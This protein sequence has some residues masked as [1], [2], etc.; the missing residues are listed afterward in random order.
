MQNIRKQIEVVRAAMAPSST[1]NKSSER[2]ALDQDLVKRR[3]SLLKQDVDTS[4]ATEEGL[5]REFERE[6]EKAKIALD[7]ETKDETY[8]QGIAQIQRLYDNILKR[9]EDINVVQDYGGYDTQVITPPERGKVMIS[10]VLLIFASAL[11]IGSLIGFAGACLVDISDKS[12]RT[13]EEIRQGMTCPVLGY[14]PRFR[15]DAETSRKAQLNGAAPDASLCTYYQPAMPEAEAYRSVRTALFFNAHAQGYKVIQITSPK[16]GDGKTTLAANLAFS[17]AQSGKKILLVDADL[18]N[19]CVSKVFPLNS[20]VGLS[21]VLAD[22]LDLASAIQPSLLPGLSILPCGPLPSNPAELLTSPR[23]QELLESL[24][25]QYDFVLV[26]TPPLL[27]VTDPSVVAAR[28]DGVLLT[29][30]LSLTGRSQAQQAQETLASLRANLLGVVV[31]GISNRSNSY[32]YGSSY[33]YG[34]RTG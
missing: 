16:K 29:I 20:A 33:G 1:G 4:R 14:I 13:P 21:S 8:R 6:Q 12:F 23:L 31:N 34:E 5:D 3:I 28:V 2:L 27:T 18:R 7:Q 15:P 30:R 32:G 22:G 24:R 11:S 10:G 25:E 9:L 26:D 19:P 17:I